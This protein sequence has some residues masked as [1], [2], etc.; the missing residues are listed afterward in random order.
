[1]RA[2]ICILT[3]TFPRFRGD[4]AAPFMGELATA[5]SKESEVFVLLPFD[6]KLDN[7]RSY[8]YK[9]VSYSYFIKKWQNLG[10]SRT[11]KNDQKIKVWSL[12]LSPFLIF[13]ACVSLIRLCR[14]EKID[15]VSA[16]WIIPNGFIAY[17]G[18]I[19]TKTPY[20][21]TIPGSD[22]YL[23]GKNWLY[24]IMTY[25]ASKNASC[26]I[27]D[28]G[29]YL[30]QFNKII[31]LSKKERVIGYGVDT[32]KFKVKSKPKDLLTKFGI[33]QSQ[34][35]ILGVGRLVTKK[36][37]IYLIRAVAKLVAKKIDFKL[38]IVGDGDEYRR[39]VEEVEGLGLEK[40]II[41][42]GTISYSNLSRY[43]NLADIFV[44]PSI[45]DE[46]GN[47]DA[48]PVAMME[49]MSSGLPVVATKF[50]AGREIIKE[51][52]NGYLAQQKSSKDIAKGML[53]FLEPKNALR[54]KVR[55]IAVENFSSLITAKKYNSIFSEVLE[56]ENR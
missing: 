9:I 11:L 28:S 14:R 34:R 43:Y 23:G 7:N 52:I 19:F 39:L 18:Y 32:L 6:N 10:Y 30:D 2:K 49:A 50:S 37:F 36:G 8:P 54:A 53:M 31:K 55:Q 24:R 21:I 45:Q 25:L 15:L 44:M 27:A 13:M 48:S 33:N 26:I 42:A 47:I 12:L 22:I 5:L 56:N 40:Y 46:E 20:T 29:Y 4:T 35:V 38:I 41:F 17:I 1:M 16:H 3:H 51:G